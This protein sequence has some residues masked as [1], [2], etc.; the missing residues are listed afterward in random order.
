M[1]KTIHSFFVSALFYIKRE[2]KVADQVIETPFFFCLLSGD[3]TTV[4]S[5]CPTNKQ[6]M[7]LECFHCLHMLDNEG[8]PLDL[9]GS[10]G[11]FFLLWAWSLLLLRLQKQVFHCIFLPSGISLCLSDF[12]SRYHQCH[13]FF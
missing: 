12:R 10:V 7:Q 5:S 13:I 2:G 4:M 6:Q 9:S 8:F 1:A 3:I 11:G